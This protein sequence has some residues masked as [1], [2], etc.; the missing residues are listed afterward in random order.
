MTSPSFLAAALLFAGALAPETAQ[1]VTLDLQVTS[2]RSSRGLIHLCLTR[3]ARH[4]PDCGHDPNAI[5]RTVAV[6]EAAAIRVGG[7]APGRYAVSVIHDENGNGKLD[8]V[9][10]IPREGFGFSRN[11]RVRFG[12]PSFDA[13]RIDLRPGITRQQVRMQYLL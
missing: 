10:G 6:R 11:P 9:V 8:T 13:V 7:I 5:K 3:E 2:L 12:P 1:T 4:F